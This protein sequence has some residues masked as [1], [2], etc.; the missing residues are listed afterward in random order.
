ML[1]QS[2]RGLMASLGGAAAAC[3]AVCGSWPLVAWA[4]QQPMPVIGLLGSATPDWYADR[5]RAFRAGLGETG[6]VEGR[7]IKIDYRWVEGHNDRLPRLAAE[8]VQQQ[9]ALIATLG[10]TPSALAAK[11]ATSTIP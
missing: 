9:V 10:N 11:A 6:Y 2:R 7:N 8:L 4:Q 3:A 1:D 5:L